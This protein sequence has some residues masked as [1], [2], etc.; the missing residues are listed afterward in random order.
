MTETEGDKDIC[1]VRD[2]KS[3]ER[4]HKMK[5][6]NKLTNEKLFQF[7]I[8]PGNDMRARQDLI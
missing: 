4:Q 1:N 3:L 5:V 6:L 8:F 2:M 7:N